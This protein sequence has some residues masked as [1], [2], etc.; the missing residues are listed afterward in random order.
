MP[1]SSQNEADGL[2]WQVVGL[3]LGEKGMD[4]RR[5]SEPDTLVDLVNARFLDARTIARRNGHTGYKVQD[6]DLFLAP[7]N[8]DVTVTDEWFYGH[9]LKVYDPADAELVED[10]HYPLAGQA[11]GTFE[12]NDK[13]VVWTGDR[14]I[15]EG[16]KG[17][18]A[19][20]GDRGIPAY[21][22]VQEDAAFSLYGGQHVDTCLTTDYEVTA[23]TRTTGVTVGIKDRSSGL[24]LFTQTVGFSACTAV[25]V[26]NS[27]GHLLL[28]VLDAGGFWVWRWLGTSWGHSSLIEMYTTAFDV[29]TSEDGCEVIWD[30]LDPSGVHT[31]HLGGFAGGVPGTNHAW[32]QEPYT[33]GCHPS[34]NVKLAVAV[35]PNGDIAYA[36][37]SLGNDTDAGLYCCQADSTLVSPTGVT[38][39]Q[40]SVGSMWVTAGGHVAITFRGLSSGFGKYDYTVY[41][42]H[43][44][45][46][47][48][49]FGGDYSIHNYV[50]IFRV[51]HLNAVLSAVNVFNAKLLT[52][53]FTV[54][55]EVFAW[56]YSTNSSTAFLIGNDAVPQVCGIADR[57]VVEIKGDSLRS[58]QFDPEDEYKFVW[59]R[60][61]N[62]GEYF[63]RGDVRIGYMNFMPKLSTAT[64]GLGTYLA[65]SHVRC[66]DGV[67]LGDAGFHDYPAI[68]TLANAS[69]GNVSAGEHFVRI[70]PVRY[71]SQGERFQG[72]AITSGG[73]G[74]PTGGV[75]VS[76]GAL[77]LSVHTIPITNHDD[78]KLEIYMTPVGSTVF[79]YAGVVDNDKDSA[80]VNITLTVSDTE[81]E[82]APADPHAPGVD[83][84]QEMEEFG[85]VGCEVLAVSGDRL[86]GIGGQVPAGCAQF[87]KL[88]E[89]GEGVGF[90]DL[91]NTQ[92]F[93]ASGNKLTS[94][95]SFSD[96]VLVAFQAKRYYSL[97]GPGPSNFGI[98]GFDVPELKVA[99]GALNHWGTIATPIGLL[100]W[101][102]EGPRALSGNYQNMFIGEPIAPL[103]LTMTPSGV[104]F[105]L[106]T[107]EVIWYTESGNALLYNFG[108]RIGRF[109]RW[110]GIPA[111]GVSDKRIVTLNGECWTPSSST[112]RDYGRS[113]VFSFETGNVRLESL[114][115]GGNRIRSLGMTGKWVGEHTVT[116]NV[117]HDGSPDWIERIDWV[118]GDNSVLNT[119]WTNL[120]GTQ[121]DALDTVDKTG[122]Y[123]NFFRLEKQDCEYIR[124]KVTDSG[125][126]GFIPWELSFEMAS[127]GGKTRLA[128]QTLHRNG[129]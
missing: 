68:A 1:K 69:G 74:G 129:E 107:S 40:A 29:S 78:V 98:G 57:E 72:A 31:L 93:D 38:L 119:D 61:Y 109:A 13:S 124:V 127:K 75:V 108:G 104:R 46:L 35:A 60:P 9:G 24:I 48:S 67:E 65:G 17:S 117:Y 89:V 91:I 71:T 62:A 106:D 20:W 27:G 118:P 103:A 5:P 110:S 43:T 111:A 59:S 77:S 25:R 105:Q 101:S 80:L 19:M 47:V 84:L 56:L 128:A 16:R 79:R 8:S 76:T 94:I 112:P 102:E 95:A 3:P 49:A 36:W 58:V 66:W 41:A 33:A 28:F 70:Y 90:G 120:T 55:N 26:V 10:E 42:K 34:I 85:P 126:D 114:L 122:R 87:S 37:T 116:F 88:Y 7:P 32:G 82:A 12:S 45:N 21:L 6:D 14:L 97:L 123:D 18:H 23:V 83:D 50:R 2:I 121:I 125:N 39:L 113:F 22:P 99:A 92:I 51:D 52:K 81:L 4:A 30:R 53:A 100:F 115:Q 54:G 64:F 11:K 15:V 86:W 96:S 63:R 73:G 44:P